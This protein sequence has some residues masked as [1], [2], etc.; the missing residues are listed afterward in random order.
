[1]S[2]MPLP[3]APVTSFDMIAPAVDLAERIANTPFVPT[4]LR[5]KPEEVLACILYGHEIGVGPMESLAQIA[6]IE[7][8]PA[9]SAQLMRARVYAHG[10]ELWTD[11]ATTTKV[12]LC[13]RR[14][15]SQHV[16]K[17][18]WTMDDARKAN[19]AG[20]QNWARYPRAM[21]QA[22]AT[23]ELCRAFFPDVL[24]AARLVAEEV[25]DGASPY[26]L[27]G[28]PEE[29]AEAP[30]KVT[31][32]RPA[33]RAV[34]PAPAPLAPVPEPGRP[35]LPGEA[36]DV[37]PGPE[38]EPAAGLVMMSDSQRKKM[39]ATLREAGIEDRNVRLNYASNIVGRTVGSANELT[40]EEASR[41]IDA[42]A[43]LVEELAQPV[44]VPGPDQLPLPDE[45]A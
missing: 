39:H 19:L 29:A 1:M 30:E 5:G 33:P 17:V 43:A 8:K 22:R 16:H 18:T 15:G 27:Y 24:G 3:A 31:R 23:A 20:R 41:V 2:L 7:G 11:E 26:D 28:V 6:V 38:P 40:S 32:R 37:E 13:G 14:N 45:E 4:G 12:T 34:A 25:A 36:L 9:I 10:H 42:A 35:P 44:D 21:L